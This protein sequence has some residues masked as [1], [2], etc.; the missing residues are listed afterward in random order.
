MQRTYL[1]N[2][3]DEAS[4]N[5][6]EARFIIFL[7][8]NNPDI[9]GRHRL[10]ERDLVPLSDGDIAKIL[11]KRDVDDQEIDYDENL[12]DPGLAGPTSKGDDYQSNNPDSNDSESNG[13]TWNEGHE[14]IP[15][16]WFCVYFKK[17]CGKLFGLD[18]CTQDK[19]DIELHV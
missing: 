10:N 1:G 8:Q 14:D 15:K 4:I 19:V 12:Y 11:E 6:E 5:E 13:D 3:E 2:Y 9:Q 17:Q 7:L 16:G 18:S